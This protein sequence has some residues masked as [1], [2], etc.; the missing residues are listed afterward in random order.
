MFII[1]LVLAAMSL[2][3]GYLTQKEKKLAIKKLKKDMQEQKPDKKS[4]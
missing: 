3:T 4:E 1:G 2:Y